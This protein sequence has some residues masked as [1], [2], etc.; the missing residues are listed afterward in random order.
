[1]ADDPKPESGASCG[2]RVMA[3]TS[4]VTFWPTN[5]DL[6]AVAYSIA[7]LGRANRSSGEGGLSSPHGDFLAR[8]MAE[9]HVLARP[10]S[11]ELADL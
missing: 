6:L 8:A 1:V 5:I 2:P 3:F 7:G 4:A 11:L 9:N 10:C